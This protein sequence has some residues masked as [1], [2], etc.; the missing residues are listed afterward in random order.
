MFYVF[1]PFKN[2][3]TNIEYL[4]Y[5]VLFFSKQDIIYK[6]IVCDDGSTD[7]TYPKIKEYIDNL[8]Y[9]QRE[10]ISLEQNKHNLGKTRTINKLIYQNCK[11]KNDIIV[12][13]D[14][15]AFKIDDKSFDKLCHPVINKIADLNIVTS[16]NGYSKHFVWLTKI[17][18]FLFK[19]SFGN[20]HCPNYQRSLLLTFVG[21]RIFRRSV[22]DKLPKKLKTGG[23]YD[24]EMALNYLIKYHNLNFHIFSDEITPSGSR[25][26]SKSYGRPISQ[27]IP[28]HNLW[29]KIILFYCPFPY[30]C[31]NWVLLLL[32]L[33]F[34]FLF[35]GRWVLKII[36]VFI[37][38]FI[39]IR[40]N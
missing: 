37:L 23:C 28:I 27:Y 6:L 11:D 18:C 26:A 10:K 38:L 35:K 24:M 2:E 5:N 4:K 40:I 25:K 36:L 1:I 22:W 14:A 29:W 15:S 9:S 3:H 8:P 34:I 30:I 13:W 39:L 21:Q 31:Y 20:H 32:M 12:T 7:Q 19:T 17:S 33:Y 16:S